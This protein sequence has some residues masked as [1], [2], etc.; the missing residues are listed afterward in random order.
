VR[1]P[2]PGT[3]SSAAHSTKLAQAI[4]KCA[5]L[6]AGLHPL[7]HLHAVSGIIDAT[8]YHGQQAIKKK[9]ELGKLS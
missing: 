9:L 3:S 2:P 6:C 5:R 8:V 1:L 7:L 4:G